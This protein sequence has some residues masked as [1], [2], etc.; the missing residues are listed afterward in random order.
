MIG[1]IAQGYPTLKQGLETLATTQVAVFNQKVEEMIARRFGWSEMPTYI[2]HY[3][4]FY[5]FKGIV[6]S[7]CFRATHHRDLD[8]PMELKSLEGVIDEVNSRF[9]ATTKGPG[10]I[11]MKAF[12]EQYP[13]R[14]LGEIAD[15]AVRCFTREVD[16]P[17]HWDRFTKDGQGV[18]LVFSTVRTEIPP[19]ILGG[20]CSELFVEVVYDHAAL[21]N[22]LQDGFAESLDL[23]NGCVLAGPLTDAGA[24]N[25]RTQIGLAEM[26]GLAGIAAKQPCFEPEKEWRHAIVPFPDVAVPWE[27]PEGGGKRFLPVPMRRGD[28][29]G[30]IERVIV[31]SA[32]PQKTMRDVEETLR[33]AGYGTG[34]ALMP[35][36]A[37]SVHPL[38]N[39]PS[40]VTPVT[41]RTVT[42]PTSK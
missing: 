15:A 8:D 19:S 14:R 32:D 6:G 36:V 20:Q 33:A 9:A 31:R 1:Y 13:K 42:T 25:N 24:I 21:R 38:D 18:C 5:A 29:R 12:A 40:P 37:V 17:Y 23:Y 3:T 4:G 16:S 22:R 39:G 27:R 28:A 2:C 34:D 7:Q 41:S 10:R 30:L 11:L 26:V 35:E